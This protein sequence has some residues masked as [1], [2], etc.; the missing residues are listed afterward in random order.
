MLS[1]LKVRSGRWPRLAVLTTALVATAGARAALAQTVIVRTAPQGS[2]I[3]V[4]Y[5][6]AQPITATAEGE[7]DATLTVPAKTA[8]SDVQIHVDACGTMVR[9]HVV[10]RGLQT[11]AAAPGCTRTDF[12]SVFLMRPATTFVVDMSPD[13]AVHVSQ[14]PPPPEWILRGEEARKPSSGFKGEPG[15]GVVLSAGVGLSSISDATDLFCGTASSC[16]TGGG[17]A[18]ALAADVWI[19]PFLAA[20]VGYLNPSA[21][22]VSGKGDT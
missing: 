16:E 5:N 22:T 17:G 1:R 2:T 15:K 20:H 3:E 12:P 6:G 11:P 7:G 8:E 18:V 19:L 13:T 4:I 9:V 10:T 14:G 21:F